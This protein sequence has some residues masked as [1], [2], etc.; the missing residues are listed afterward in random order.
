VVRRAVIA[1]AI[2]CAAS[3]AW[4][5]D[6]PDE[7]CASLGKM[8]PGLP[9]PEA[10]HVPPETLAHLAKVKLTSRQAREYRTVLRVSAK[11]G[12]NFAGHY[13][14]A[15]WGCGSSC[16]SLAVVDQR[17]GDVFFTPNLK[18]VAAYANEPF[19]A[20]T[21]QA[22]SRLLI[23]SGAPNEDLSRQGV[24][25]YLWAGRTFKLLKRLTY[26]QVCPAAVAHPN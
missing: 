20:L 3:S 12:P 23:V 5:Q 4:A 24:S 13:T 21:F 8:P 17:T 11:G 6:R 14:L 25:A 2:A 10:F 9:R 7:S 16:G 26:A 1:F 22:D 19:D 18:F 15:I